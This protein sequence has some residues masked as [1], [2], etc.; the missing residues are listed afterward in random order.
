M[1]NKIL[2]VLGFTGLIFSVVGATMYTLATT[3]D[4]FYNIETKGC[5]A[6]LTGDGKV[7]DCPKNVPHNPKWTEKSSRAQI[8]AVYTKQ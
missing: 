8:A 4:G 2:S 1:V 7:T 6:I 5:V 3:P